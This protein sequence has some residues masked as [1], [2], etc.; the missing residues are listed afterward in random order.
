M[1]AGTVYLLWARHSFFFKI[2]FTA[3]KSPDQ[4][5]RDIQVGCPLGVHVVATVPGTRATESALHQRWRNYRAR[6]EWFS[7]EEEALWLVLGDF[8]VRKEAAV[9][10]LA[11]QSPE[12]LQTMLSEYRSGRV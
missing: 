4:R 12:V 1:K 3:D 5:V 7:F 2:G 8:G 9:D 11:S 10:V 6:G